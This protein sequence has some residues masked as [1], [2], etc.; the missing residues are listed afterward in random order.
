MRAQV[1]MT[2]CVPH[3]VLNPPSL[4][5]QFSCLSFSKLLCTDLRVFFCV[6]AVSCPRPTS[7]PSSTRRTGPN[8]PRKAA[9]D[10]S[11]LQTQLGPVLLPRP[12]RPAQ[13]EVLG[14]ALPRT[15]DG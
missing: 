8:D 13:R 2:G 6:H 5:S 14:R 7:A 11:G 4:T 3:F 15:D 12:R 9:H 10:P 1:R